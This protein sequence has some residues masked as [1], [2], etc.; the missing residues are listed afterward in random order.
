MKRWALMQGAQCANVVEQ[1][2]QP[3]IGG[4]WVEVTG[5]PVGPG[6]RLVSGDWLPA[7]PA[8]QQTITSRQGKRALVA[9]ELYQPA[10]AAMNAMAEPAKTLALIDWDAPTWQRDDPTLAAMAG[11]LGLTEAQLD[12]LFAQAATL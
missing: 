5:F 10:L 6:S 1:E 9:V 12:A 4:E 8:V 2:D 11:A 3:Q 7:Q